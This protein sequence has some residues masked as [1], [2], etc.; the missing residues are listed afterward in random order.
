MKIVRV[1]LGA[2]S[3][4]INIGASLPSPDAL[5]AFS[6]KRVLLVSDS[7]VAPLHQDA[8]QTLL[9]DAGLSVCPVVVEA[10]ENSKQLKTIEMLYNAALD[11]G[12]DRKSLIAALGG[13]M[14]GDAAGFAAATYMRGINF[15]QIPTSLLAMVDSSVGG[16]TGVNLPR[17]KN[18]VGAFHQPIHVH[19]DLNYLKT[20]PEREFL[21]GLA[22]VVKYAVIWDASFM[23]QLE[24]NAGQILARNLDALESVVA[25]CCEIKAE[26]VSLDEREGGVRAILNFGHTFAHAV[27]AQASYA[28]ILHG[29]AVSIGMTF[30][31]YLSVRIG[32][33]SQDVA[34]RIVSLLK[35]YRLPTAVDR[36]SIPDWTTVKKIMKTDKKS[37]SGKQLFVLA[38]KLGMVRYACE[39]AEADQKSVFE[40]MLK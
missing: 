5:K 7:N 17:G 39:A 33:L 8:V 32:H 24:K 13:G 20:L 27:E 11:T 2:R 10:G 30:A 26:V 22:E 9:S 23:D 6:G 36:S 31:S 40:S 34:E 18:L 19:A 14:I 37:D 25:R 4:D 15:I 3:Y 28:D 16:K 35:A 1:D 21:S 29:E 12:L 38:E